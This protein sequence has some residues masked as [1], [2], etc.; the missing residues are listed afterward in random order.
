[1]FI[2]CASF[3]RLP[4]LNTPLLP[5]NTHET[6]PVT[7][8]PFPHLHIYHLQMGANDYLPFFIPVAQ[9]SVGSKMPQ[10]C[11]GVTRLH[12]TPGL[13]T[14]P[15]QICF[16]I[17]ESLS[18]TRTTLVLH[19]EGGLGRKHSS[20]GGAR[21][22]CTISAQIL[23]SPCILAGTHTVSSPRTH[24]TH[25]TQRSPLQNQSRL[26]GKGEIVGQT[27]AREAE[28]VKQGRAGCFRA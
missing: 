10:P 21:A 7:S 17:L 8:C 26:C 6:H 11:W 5:A 23:C 18:R 14:L 28:E 3:Q 16:S 24:T 12:T 19:T 4:G 22:I 27:P 15:Y 13:L 2:F 20:F 25:F 1:M 9:L